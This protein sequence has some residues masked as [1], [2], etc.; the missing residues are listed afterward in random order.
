MARN[1]AALHGFNCV[2][3]HPGGAGHRHAILD[4]GS[5]NVWVKHA[6]L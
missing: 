2:S 5:G 3:G 6:A 1:L 4:M